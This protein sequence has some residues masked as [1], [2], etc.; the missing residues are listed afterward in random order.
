MVTPN[1]TYS[2]QIYQYDIDV[3]KNIVNQSDISFPLYNIVCVGGNTVNFQ[4]NDSLS[5]DD[6]LILNNIIN[7]YIYTT[8]R[9]TVDPNV[10]KDS[11]GATL[12]RIKHAPTGWT[13]QLR[14]IEFTTSTINSLINNDKDKKSLL[15]CVVKFYDVDNNLIND[16]PTA[17][18]SCTKTIIDLE[19]T[20]DYYIIG[21]RLIIAEVPTTNVYCSIVAVPDIPA[22]YGGSKVVVQNM[23]LHFLTQNNNSIIIDGRSAKQLSYSAVNHT[24]KLRIIIFHD[25]GDK[26]LISVCLE[27]YKQ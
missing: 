7:D 17:D 10:Q 18:L 11:D 4:F 15:D 6:I 20:Y 22:L 5:D 19:P 3:L 16:Q 9:Q 25:V 27:H 14:G 23:N 26:N 8:P 21:G 12:S 2:Y 13:Y 1:T 24:N